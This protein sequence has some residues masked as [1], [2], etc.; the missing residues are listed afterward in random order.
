MREQ[1]VPY[2][3]AARELLRD[4]LF[5]AARGL[6][7]DRDWGQV[8]MAEVA[9]AAGVSRQTVYNQFGSR[10]EFAQ[11]FIL[12]EADR[13]V[14]SVRDAVASNADRP[15]EA[16]AAA[17]AVFLR[18]A[19]HDPLVRAIV[20]GDGTDGLLALVTTHGEPVLERATD[21]LCAVIMEHW[22]GVRGDDARLLSEGVVRLAISYAALPSGES[23][24]NAAQV[25]RLLGPFIEQALG[26]R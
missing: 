4:T 11:A 19:E 12:A 26:R 15:D 6:L 10:E 9:R 13:F 23:S 1:P 21:Q 3:V 5:T 7:A 18:A 22:Q 8:T 17:F 20:S 2:P 24:M 16:L 25:A 14:G